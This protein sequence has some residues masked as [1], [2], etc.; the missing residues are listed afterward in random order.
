MKKLIIGKDT[1]H[2][3]DLLTIMTKRDFT[4]SYKNTFFGLLWLV[5]NPFLQMLIV[6]FVFTYFVKEPIKNYYYFLYI[7]LLV[8]N[9]FSLCLSKCTPSIVYE[10]SLIKKAVF[11]RAIIPLSIIISNLLRFILALIIFLI[12]VFI[13]GTLTYMSVL[14][15]AA[16]LFLLLVFTI[17]LCFLFS[18]LNV[19]F[20]D[21]N[22]LVQ[23]L[24][25]LW[26][27]ANPIVYTLSQIPSNLLWMWNFNPLTSILQ[28]FQF[29]LLG[30]PIPK[31]SILVFNV[32]IIATVSVI[33][34]IIFHRESR[35]F[36]D[37]L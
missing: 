24:L 1:K 9:F 31:L 5:V 29:G 35:T 33:G 36:D 10:R 28:L 12:P 2:F 15:I 3:L 20:R 32:M 19:R 30:N 14:Y 6:G 34:I 13:L 7:G 4:V 25:I 18:A 17:A 8:W 11:P 21:I 22:F 37:W 23:A 16:A 26:F 27:Y